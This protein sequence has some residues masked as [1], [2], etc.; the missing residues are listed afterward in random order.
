MTN[1][2]ITVQEAAER[3]SLSVRAV[4][5]RIQAGTLQAR[6]IGPGKTMPYLVDAADVERIR[7]EVTAA[8]DEV[9]EP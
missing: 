6:K 2:E 8:R 9:T 3:L 1:Q 4:Q 5:K 7:A